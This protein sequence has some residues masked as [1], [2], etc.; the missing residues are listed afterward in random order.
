VREWERWA[1]GTGVAYVVFAVVGFFFVPDPPQPTT[2]NEGL[3]AY[4]STKTEELSFQVFFFALAGISFLWFI[5]TLAAALRRAEDGP[6]GLA[7]IAVTAGATANAVFLG[8]MVC[9]S[10]LAASAD[11]ILDQGVARGLYDLGRYA[12]TLSGVPAA[13]FVLAV[14]LGTLRT[15][16]LPVAVGWAGLLLALVLVLDVAAATI[17]DDDDFGP[18]GSYGVITF[19]LFLAWVFVTSL[20]LMQRVAPRRRVAET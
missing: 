6:T 10:A 7:A 11:T 13:A 20:F 19:L 16:F 17:G 9:W 5:G 1:A 18:T 12:Y 2:S 3:L 4:F 8:G 14:S 15:R